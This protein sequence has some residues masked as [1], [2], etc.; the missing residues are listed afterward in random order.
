[1]PGSNTE[2]EFFKF[3]WLANMLNTPD[4]LVDQIAD[5]DA[6]IMYTQVVKDGLYFH[7]FQEWIEN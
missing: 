4:V 5:E 6:V 3:L 2:R 1:V 7:Q